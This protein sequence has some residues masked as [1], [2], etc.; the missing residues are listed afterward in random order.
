MKGRLKL[1]P[2][3][4]KITLCFFV[5]TI[6]GMAHSIDWSIRDGD[7]EIKWANRDKL[8]FLMKWL[9]IS[10]RMLPRDELK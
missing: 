8:R 5:F 7:P 3:T 6:L 9:G 4:L 2:L 1:V 10:Y